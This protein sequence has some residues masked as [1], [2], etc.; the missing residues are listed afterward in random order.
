LLLTPGQ[1]SDWSPDSS[2]D[3][4][5]NVFHRACV[6]AGLPFGY[7]PHSLRHSF[8]TLL[9]DA[10]TDLVLIQHLLGHA[11]I[12][13]ILTARF[14]MYSQG[15]AIDLVLPEHAPRVWADPIQL[16]EVFANLVSNAV[17][18][19]DSVQAAGPSHSISWSTPPP[20]S[21]ASPGAKACPQQAAISIPTIRFAG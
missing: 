6:A 10:G 20:L 18:Y 15:R 12:F 14:G 13:N 11:Q 2:L 8:A 17:R 5:R 7:T 9:L 1:V 16:R 19:M 21:L 4:A 3:T